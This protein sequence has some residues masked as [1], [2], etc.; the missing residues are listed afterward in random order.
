MNDDL[1][2]QKISKL[3]ENNTA[4]I[5]YA[6]N[7]GVGT[8]IN[9]R[10]TETGKTI[11][12]LSINVDSS[13]EVL[14]VKDSTDNQYKAV[15]FK[16]AE[17][18]SEK[19][20]QIRKTKPT[21]DKKIIDYTDV[22]IEVFYLFVKL[23]DT[24]SPVPTSLQSTWIRKSNSC[25]QFVG[26]YERCNYASQKAIAGTYYSGLPYQT[27]TSL[28]DCLNDDSSPDA[29]TPH[30]SKDKNGG[31]A[32]WKYFS[33]QIGAAGEQSMLAAL[34]SHDANFN[35]GY[36][37]LFGYGSILEC[38]GAMNI[39]GWET[40]INSTTGVPFTLCY[41]SF[42]PGYTNDCTSAMQAAGYCDYRGFISSKCPLP[43]QEAPGMPSVGGVDN[44]W[45]HQY[46]W[47]NLPY[48]FMYKRHFFQNFLNGST[49]GGSYYILAVND[50][51]IPANLPPGF[52]PWVPGCPSNAPNG[53][54]YDGSGGNRFPD[55]PVPLKKRDMKLSNHKAEIWLG[56]S[57][58][59]EAI[60]LYELGVSDLFSGMYNSFI[61]KADE[62]QVDIE[63]RLNRGFTVST[64]D[65]L[66]DSTFYKNWNKNII[67]QRIDPKMWV[68][69]LNN[70]PKIQPLIAQLTGEP[71]NYNLSLFIHHLYQKTINLTVVDNKTQ[72]IHLKLGLSPANIL[73]NLDC[74]GSSQYETPMPIG[75]YVPTQVWQYQKNV[76]ITIKDWKIDST[77]NNLDTTKIVNSWNKEYISRNYLTMFRKANPLAGSTTNRYRDQAGLF[78]LRPNASTDINEL[79]SGNHY[80]QFNY[81]LAKIGSDT[82]EPYLSSLYFDYLKTASGSYSDAYNSRWAGTSTKSWWEMWDKTH[83]NKT[84][85]R[86]SAIVGYDINMNEIYKD[87]GLSAS[88]IYEGG[89]FFEYFDYQSQGKNQIVVP[90]LIRRLRTD[91][92]DVPLQSSYP[93]LKDRNTILNKTGNN[94]FFSDNSYRFTETYPFLPLPSRQYISPPPFSATR[95][96]L[97]NSRNTYTYFDAPTNQDYIPGSNFLPDFRIKTSSWKN[98]LWAQIIYTGETKVDVDSYK[99]V[100][101]KLPTIPSKYI[102]FTTNP[103]YK[104]AEYNFVDSIQQPKTDLETVL[105]PG[106]LDV[107]K[108][109]SIK[110]PTNVNLDPNMSFLLYIYPNV[111][112]TKK[113]KEI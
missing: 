62:T 79:Y 15:T 54:P 77:T 93:H 4:F 38:S 86:L 41:F 94:F 46:G 71:F 59:T 49:A 106:K 82:E 66:I 102:K 61:T 12:A 31:M 81:S 70:T 109:V 22:D 44:S 67:D 47:F 16:V 19:I 30:G 21:D 113:K 110:K 43:G 107:T 34:T 56:S 64:A 17:K 48:Q 29:M 90:S 99:E 13:G 92:T 45:S 97:I 11:Q 80:E 68:Y 111:V 10:N 28:A 60:K 108:Q 78:L 20:I 52:F 84:S 95:T 5:G 87:W 14:V 58:K 25:T 55:G 72:V 98:K 76:T 37:K 103:I 74:K 75:E 6:L 7:G 35:T 96:L 73:S 23:I 53:G 8:K 69:I 85:K 100:E 91:L 51:Q 3:L 63:N 24:G 36:K 18:V 104:T 83:Y 57:K 33:T 89:I 50:D 2:V 40:R 9:V 65:T 26:A 42:L 88:L 101:F 105:S 27:Y 32:G 112:V 39:Q 1:V